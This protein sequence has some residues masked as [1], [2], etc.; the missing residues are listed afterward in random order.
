MTAP[1]AGDRS[2]RLAMLLSRI[3][4]GDVEAFGAFYQETSGPLYGVALRLLRDR[5]AAAELLQEAYVSVWQHASAYDPARHEPATWLTSI[6]RH[7][8]LDQVR[9]PDTGVDVASPD[10]DREPV[11]VLEDEWAAADSMLLTGVAGTGANAC[12]QAVDTAARQAFALALYFGLS[13]AELATRLGA[14]RADVRRGL[15]GALDGLRSSSLDDA[16][17]LRG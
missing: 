5:A 7:R 12:L 2:A 10:V 9:A 1:A 13:P 6:V 14:S 16:G 11:S 3:A 15:R 17:G 8:C 4:H